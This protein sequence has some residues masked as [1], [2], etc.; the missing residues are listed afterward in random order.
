MTPLGALRRRLDILPARHR[1]RPVLI[2]AV[3]ITVM[4][5]A[6]PLAKPATVCPGLMGPVWPVLAR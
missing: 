4:A 3:V 5:V 6:V 2:G 1:S